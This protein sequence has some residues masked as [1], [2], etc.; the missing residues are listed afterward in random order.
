MELDD[1][2]V[3]DVG[4][5][6]PLHLGSDAVPHWGMKQG[7]EKY[8]YKKTPK[9]NTVGLFG[10][11]KTHRKQA[12]PPTTKVSGPHGQHRL[13]RTTTTTTKITSTL[14]PSAGSPVPPS[15]FVAVAI[16]RGLRLRYL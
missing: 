16:S 12:H 1:K 7:C 3:V 10:L 6:V 2:R 11:T 15:G 5:D 9:T 14:K 13:I 8:I 4:Q